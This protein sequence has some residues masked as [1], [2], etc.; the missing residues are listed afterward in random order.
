MPDQL[1]LAAAHC[2][3][4]LIQ[5]WHYRSLP[6]DHSHP[7]AGIDHGTSMFAPT[8]GLLP[9]VSDLYWP[10]SVM[11]LARRVLCPL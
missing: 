11:C 2:D 1:G 8:V 7:K 6:S 10:T 9:G 3:S 5:S 4:T